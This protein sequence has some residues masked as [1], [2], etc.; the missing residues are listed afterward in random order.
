R[1]VA[2]GVGDST[3]TLAFG[4]AAEAAPFAHGVT[5]QAAPFARDLTGTVQETRAADNAVTGAEHLAR[6]V[7]PS[8][9]Q[10]VLDVQDGAYGALGNPYGV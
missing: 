10:D 7:T 6:S 8:Y 2:G 4:V 3:T 1:P 5:G 9:A